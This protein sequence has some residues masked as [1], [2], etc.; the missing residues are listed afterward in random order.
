MLDALLEC[1]HGRLQARFASENLGETRAEQAVEC[2]LEQ[3][4]RVD[5]VVLGLDADNAF[6]DGFACATAGTVR[7]RNV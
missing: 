2:M 3:D 5:F 7:K 1:T 4:T 6:G